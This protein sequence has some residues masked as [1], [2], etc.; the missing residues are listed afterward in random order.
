MR[1]FWRKP[2]GTHFERHGVN[3][4]VSAIGRKPPDSVYHRS[5]GAYAQWLTKNVSLKSA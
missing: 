2:N 1:R 4:K 3:D 5:P